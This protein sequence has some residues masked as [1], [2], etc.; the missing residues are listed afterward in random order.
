ME[1]Q[2][3][4]ESAS[5]AVDLLIEEALMHRAVCHPY[6]KAMAD[7]Q[8]PNMHWALC[9]FA[10]HYY[11]YSEAFPR[12]LT[13]T[14]SRLDNPRHRS[15]LL[16]N[17]TEESG[18]YTDKDLCKLQE[19]NIEREWIEG[20]PHP[21]LFDRFRRA[22]GVIIQNEEALEVICW[23][24]SFLSL[25]TSGTAEEALGAIGLATESTVKAIYSQLYIAVKNLRAINPRDFVFFPLHV[26]VDDD[27]QASLRQVAI[28]YAMKPEGLTSLR[29][30]MLKALWL[31]DSFWSWMLQRAL[32]NST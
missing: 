9:D 12:Y 30:G 18:Q 25:L 19:F 15:L 4:K 14:I 2:I 27:H 22:M 31:R 23:R 5:N 21:A 32:K 20:I 8:L 26:L 11:G 10:Q 28:E 24:E 3:S 6:L 7:N 1:N 16:E 29:K 17:L 13:A